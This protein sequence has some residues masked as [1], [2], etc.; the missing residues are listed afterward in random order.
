MVVEPSGALANP[1]SFASAADLLGV[2]SL[3]LKVVVEDVEQD[4]TQNQSLRKTDSYRPPTC[5]TA[6]NSLSFA[7]QPVLNSPHCP[8]IYPMLSKLHN[9]D[10]VGDNVKVYNVNCSPPSTQPVMASLKASRLVKHDFP[11]VNPC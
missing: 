9:K 11:L 10:V 8:L 6:N 3:F 2:D 4:Q 1:P 5:A 7:I